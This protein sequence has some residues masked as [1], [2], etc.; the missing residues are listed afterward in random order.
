MRVVKM[1]AAAV[2]PPLWAAVSPL[3]P[4]SESL[5]KN[6]S[7]QALSLLSCVTCVKVHQG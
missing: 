7:D 5:V 6:L 1:L 2:E 3:W 4:L